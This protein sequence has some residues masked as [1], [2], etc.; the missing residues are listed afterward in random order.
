M[1]YGI[2]IRN[3]YKRD[4]ML[5]SIFAALSIMIVFAVPQLVQAATT[6]TFNSPTKGSVY[7]EIPD[8][9]WTDIKGATEYEVYVACTG[10]S[11]I[12][13]SYRFTVH[14]PYLDFSYAELE[15]FLEEKGLQPKERVSISLYVRAKVHGRYTDWSDRM[16]FTAKK[17]V[18]IEMPVAQI[19]THTYVDANGMAT[20]YG[21]TDRTV[22]YIQISLANSVLGNRSITC[23]NTSYCVLRGIGPLDSGSVHYGY[24]L[25]NEYMTDVI[26]KAPV[27]EQK[28]QPVEATIYTIE[29]NDGSVTFYNYTKDRVEVDT[30][31]I[32]IN[33]DVIRRC[34]DVTYCGYR[35]PT[36]KKVTY[37]IRT[38]HN[39]EVFMS[40]YKTY[41]PTQIDTPAQDTAVVPVTTQIYESVSNG[42]N[43][44]VLRASTEKNVIVDR[45]NILVNARLTRECTNTSLCTV[46]IPIDELGTSMTYGVN[47]Y[48]NNVRYWSGYKFKQL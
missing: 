4:I 18:E 28:Q 6:P 7:T 39:G 10:C 43:V 14:Q 27:R 2:F 5:R 17:K 8:V 19:N 29:H 40:D 32:Y 11:A 26:I 20:V 12:P 30:I 38:V 35:S 44:V 45:L 21:Y 31:E 24:I 36:A 42:K 46:E 16:Y 13:V 22:S 34:N 41:T 9:E 47:S 25:T 33:G 1:K 48:R 3:F 37:A 23:K 15:K